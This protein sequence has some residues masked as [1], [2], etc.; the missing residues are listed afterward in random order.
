MRNRFYVELKYSAINLIGFLLLRM[1]A[2]I[3]WQFS[4]FVCMVIIFIVYNRPVGF[5][6]FIFKCGYNFS[7]FKLSP[8]KKLKKK[9]FNRITQHTCF[10]FLRRFFFCCYFFIPP[11][12]IFF[13]DL[14][15]ASSFYHQYISSPLGKVKFVFNGNK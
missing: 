6:F 8:K 13:W 4:S 7:F 9:I 1:H 2:N 12:N 5:L 10:L 11:F 3:H 14:F 15:L